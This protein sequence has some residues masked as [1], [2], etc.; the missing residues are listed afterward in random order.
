MWR[1]PLLAL[2]IVALT[3]TL[4]YQPMVSGA[5]EVHR[6]ILTPRDV[7]GITTAHVTA[8]ARVSQLV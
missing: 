1:L 5:P 8:T 4:V 6:A 2:W 3:E 7:A